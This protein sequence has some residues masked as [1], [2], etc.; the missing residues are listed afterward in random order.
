[1]ESKPRSEIKPPAWFYLRDYDSNVTQNMW[2]DA[3]STDVSINDPH[4]AHADIDATWR[5]SF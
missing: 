2:E 1:M 3:I 5:W 4:F